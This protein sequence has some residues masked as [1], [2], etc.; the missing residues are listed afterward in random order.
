VAGAGVCE[1]RQG[2]GA[3]GRGEADRAAGGLRPAPGDDTI[4]SRS[5]MGRSIEPEDALAPAVEVG[6]DGGEEEEHDAGEPEERLIGAGRQVGEGG[7]P[8]VEED[9]LDIE[10]EEDDGDE[11]EADVE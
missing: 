7:G 10:D 1:P 11:V 8:G 9:D 6:D 3:R 4:E 2:A 5:G